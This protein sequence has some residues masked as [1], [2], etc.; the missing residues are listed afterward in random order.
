MKTAIVAMTWLAS[1]PASAGDAPTFP[2]GPADRFMALAV[3]HG[4]IYVAMTPEQFQFARGLFAMAPDTPSSLPPG[5]S[6]RIARREDGSAS[7]VWIDG[8]QACAPMRLGKEGA[9]MLMQVGRGEIVHNG[10]GL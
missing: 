7:V 8:D 2:C 3:E 10:H 5:E 4:E 6:A 1:I 9:D